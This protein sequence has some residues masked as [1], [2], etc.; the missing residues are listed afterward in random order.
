MLN[1][2]L[3]TFPAKKIASLTLVAICMP[4]PN[5]Y[6]IEEVYVPGTRP[7]D[8]NGL[9]WQDYLDNQATA[10]QLRALYEGM[11]AEAKAREAAARQK[12]EDDLKRAEQEKCERRA[13]VN[14]E[15][16][17]GDAAQY[18]QIHNEPCRMLQATV[19]NIPYANPTGACFG[20]VQDA[21][22]L[23]VSNCN[24]F[25]AIAELDCLK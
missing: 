24:L 4:M 17:L 15:I 20:R 6:A 23:F 13:A 2:G 11:Q 14:H 7:N 8:M 3:K 19:G 12:A 22:D 1:L 25:N 18:K 9:D 5:T 10:S 21:Y 16:C